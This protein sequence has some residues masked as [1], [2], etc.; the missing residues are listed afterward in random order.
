[1]AQGLDEHVIALEQQNALK[2]VAVCKL[3][4]PHQ[5]G[6]A[7]FGIAVARDGWEDAEL[8]HLDAPGNCHGR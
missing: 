6:D 4:H 7:F 2:A 5:F 3:R 8:R 1:M